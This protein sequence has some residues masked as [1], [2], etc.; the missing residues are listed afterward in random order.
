[1]LLRCTRCTADKTMQGAGLMQAIA[2]IGT[3]PSARR[4]VRI[5]DHI[6]LFRQPSAYPAEYRQ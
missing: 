2:S 3:Q 6:G 1:M 4:A 5:R